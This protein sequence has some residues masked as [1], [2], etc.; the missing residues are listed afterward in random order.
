MLCW[1]SDHYNADIII[2]QKAESE[3]KMNKITK[4]IIEESKSVKS[5]SKNSQLESKR[6]QYDTA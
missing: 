3:S 5:Q 2:A 4:Q 6:K 1:F